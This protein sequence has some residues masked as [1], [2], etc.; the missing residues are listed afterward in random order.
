MSHVNFL[1]KEKCIYVRVRG[2]VR[3]F[4]TLWTVTHQAPL[5]TGLSRQE[6]WSGLPFPPPGDLPDPGIKPTSHPSFK[7]LLFTYL[8]RQTVQ[9]FL[10]LHRVLWEHSEVV[11]SRLSDETVCVL[12]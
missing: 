2:R 8:N 1:K 4:V 9:I 11:S 10:L 5:S 12:A 3:L 6:Y 7:S